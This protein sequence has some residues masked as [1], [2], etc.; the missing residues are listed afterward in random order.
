VE[1]TGVRRRGAR[2]VRPQADWRFEAGDVVVLL[3]RPEALITAEDKLL[4]ARDRKSVPK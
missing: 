1:A 2:S 4:R 3:G